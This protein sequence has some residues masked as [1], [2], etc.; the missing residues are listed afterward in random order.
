MIRQALLKRYRKLKQRVSEL[1]QFRRVLLELVG[2]GASVEAGRLGLDVRRYSQQRFSVE[3][4]AEVLGA[5][6]AA[7]LQG[8]LRPTEVTHV[9]VTEAAPGPGPGRPDQGRG[10][11]DL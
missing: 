9:L 2:Q 1:H 4:V 8:L 7:D 5:K 3:R 6:V 10:V 11:T